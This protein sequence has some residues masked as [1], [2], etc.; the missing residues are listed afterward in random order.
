MAGRAWLTF[1]VQFHA[2]RIIRRKHRSSK[3]KVQYLS[4]EPQTTQFVS[5]T[6]LADAIGGASGWDRR[7]LKGHVSVLVD[8]RRASRSAARL[9][10]STA[11]VG[12]A[13]GPMV[14]SSGWLAGDAVGA[15]AAGAER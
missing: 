11:I 8:M 3:W 6:C 4:F 2:A 5:L 14:S 10:R 12:L 15:D 13:N 7:L 9:V 1:V